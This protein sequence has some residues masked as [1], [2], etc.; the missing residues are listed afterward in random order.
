MRVLI[1]ACL[2]GL[3]AWRTYQRS[4][5]WRTD[6]ELWRAA[7]ATTPQRVRPAANLARALTRVGRWREAATWIEHAS[8]NLTPQDAW[9]RPYL[10]REIDTLTAFDDTLPP[11][12]LRC[13][14]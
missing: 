8:I 2:L 12:S 10:C 11:F 14:S 9:I 13:A 5:D 3:C 1:G 7:T 4:L 6:E